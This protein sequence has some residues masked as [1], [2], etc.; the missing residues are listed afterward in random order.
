MALALIFF[1]IVLKERSTFAVNNILKIMK[2]Y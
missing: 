2:Q 1:I